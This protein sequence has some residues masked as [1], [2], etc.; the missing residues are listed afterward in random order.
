MNRDQFIELVKETQEPLRRFLLILCEWDRS[1]A[2]DLAQETLLKAYLSF[3]RFEGRSRFSTWLFRIAYN[4]FYD[5]KNNRGDQTVGLDTLTLADTGQDSDSQEIG[6]EASEMFSDD[7][8]DRSFR[9]ERLYSAIKSLSDKEK[10]VVLLFYME[11]KSTFIKSDRRLSSHE[12]T[13][14]G[15][16]YRH[17]ER[18][19]FLSSGNERIRRTGI[20]FRF[21]DALRA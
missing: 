3:D 15:R 9:Y 2:D 14:C 1:S 7:E 6:H 21:P 18:V 19:S 11:E 10:T 4:C 16:I 20:A 17:Y 13:G 8:S 12:K 5:R